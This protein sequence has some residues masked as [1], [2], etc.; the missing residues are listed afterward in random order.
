[1]K[2]ATTHET[3]A[4]QGQD[5]SQKGNKLLTG[6]AVGAAVGGVVALVDKRTRTKVINSAQCAKNSTTGFVTRLREN[7]SE[8][9]DDWQHRI[10]VASGVIKEVTSDLKSLYEKVNNELNGPVQSIK[11][12]SSQL[13]ESAQDVQ[14]D[15]QDIGDK[16]KQAGEEVATKANPEL[17]KYPAP[18]PE[19]VPSQPT[20]YQ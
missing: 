9:K 4:V 18:Q 11:E 17:K 1:M 13:V 19:T 6:I 7:P 8:V 3:Q 20:R 16:V 15:L 5:P 2:Q 10:K 14:E 12:E